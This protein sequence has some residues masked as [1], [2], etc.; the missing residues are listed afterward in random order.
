[1]SWEDDQAW[2][3]ACATCSS[4]TGDVGTTPSQQN[5]LAMEFLGT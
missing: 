2:E 5:W 1:M 4:T 3:S